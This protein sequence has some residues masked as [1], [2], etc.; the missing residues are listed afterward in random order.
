MKP[1][2]FSA[3]EVII[4]EGDEGEDFYFIEEGEV[5]CTKDGVAEEVSRRLTQGD[6]FG[7]RALITNEVRA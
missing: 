5:R 7:E 1:R 4:G 2:A 6:Y 3:G